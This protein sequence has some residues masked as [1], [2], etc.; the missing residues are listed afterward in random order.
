MNLLFLQCLLQLVTVIVYGLA[1]TTPRIKKTDFGSKRHF[2]FK[3]LE[4]GT[5]ST[6]SLPGNAWSR[7]LP[8]PTGADISATGTLKTLTPIVKMKISLVNAQ[9]I[10][11]SL[12][13]SKNTL[14]EDQLEKLSFTV[15]SIP[16]D[17]KTFKKQFDEYSDPVSYKQKYMDANAFLV[18]YTN[19]FDGPGRES[20]EKEIPKQT[21]QYGARNDIWNAYDEFM[22]EKKF[23]DNKS[24]ID[25]LLG[26]LSKTINNLDLYLS[27]APIE[28]V[29]KVEKMQLTSNF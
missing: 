15:H 8:E 6:L 1:A 26:P 17:E 10:L 25:D 24:V 28:D 20:I 22:I 5:I 12:K 23:A 21:L 29:V 9:N 4:V 14:T 13:E 3:T 18:Y 27:L 19:G 16:S 7:N 2:I 11:I